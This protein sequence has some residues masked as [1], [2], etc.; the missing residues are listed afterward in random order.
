[1][2]GGIKTPWKLARSG[3]KDHLKPVNSPKHRKFVRS[4]KCVAARLAPGECNGA[5]QFCHFKGFKDS[6]TGQKGGDE[7]GFPGCWHHHLAVQH[8]IGEREFQRRY[9]VDL[10]QVTTDLAR[11]SPDPRIREKVNG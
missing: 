3:I 5:V 1:M 4:Q 10:F 2:I 11:R 6:G 9:G 7:R 8:F